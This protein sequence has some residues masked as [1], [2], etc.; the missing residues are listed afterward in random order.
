VKGIAF[1]NFLVAM[2]RETNTSLFTNRVTQGLFLGICLIGLVL[3]LLIFVQNYY[4]WSDRRKK[5]YENPAVQEQ[6]R[7]SNNQDFR[8]SFLMTLFLMVFFVFLIIKF[9]MTFL[10]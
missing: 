6:A 9:M 5:I 7:K 2:P 1:M 4:N 8:S 10:S 3:T